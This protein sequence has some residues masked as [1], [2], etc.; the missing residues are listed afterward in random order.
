MKVQTSK[1]FNKQVKKTLFTIVLFILVYILL[2]I[3]AIAAT[4]LLA[5]FGFYIVT[6]FPNVYVWIFGLAL[7]AS[8]LM[9]LFFLFKFIFTKNQN[10]LEGM[11]EIQEADQPELFG[12]IN[13]IVQE[14]ETDFPK[15]VYLTYNVNASVFYNSSFWSMFMPIRKN[16]QIGLGLINSVNKQELKAILAHEFGHFSQRSMKVGS[17]VYNLNQVIYNMLYNN[18]S[19]NNISSTIAGFS[20]IA[21][22][23]MLIPLYSIRGIQALLR[24]LYNFININY[25]AL[26]REM[27]FHADEIAANVAG[28]KA[29]SSSLLR[30]GFAD[31]A[32]NETMNFYID[33]SND[34]IHP[35]N[36][37]ADHQTVSLFLAEKNKYP[38][39]NNLPS[40]DL[41]SNIKYNKSKVNFQDQWASHPSTEDRVMAIQR[42]NIE[43]ENEKV[44]DAI[45]L[46]KGSEELITKISTWLFG[47]GNPELPQINWDTNQFKDA[48]IRDFNKNSFDEYYNDF[49]NLNSP[50]NFDFSKVDFNANT[51]GS[52][53]FFTDDDTEL[54]YELNGIRQDLAILEAIQRNEIKLKTFDYDGKKHKKQETKDL[55]PQLKLAETQKDEELKSINLKI[56]EHYFQKAKSVNREFD[57][58]QTHDTLR[59]FESQLNHQVN[60]NQQVY[61]KLAFLSQTLEFTDI[62][63]NLDNF[64]P[65]EKELKEEI[66]TLVRFPGMKEH[67]HV[68]SQS[69][70]NTFLEK[71]MV[72]FDHGTYLDDELQA[73]STAVRLYIPLIDKRLFLQK[74][75]ILDLKR[76]IQ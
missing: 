54:S 38:I 35:R 46:I 9:I 8:G 48:Y 19:V 41:E 4:G 61:D 25:M 32:L 45:S 60:F 36:I 29:C 50:T 63:K 22:I 59:E 58:R 49:Y 76:E 57:F 40:I 16:L 65:T 68:D 34:N 42:L 23:P 26:S 20:S 39:Q 18:D 43:V 37:Y 69:Q 75:I 72:Y 7:V 17:Y 14:V 5:Y 33:R 30:L 66:K 21:A 51:T 13:E 73:L 44:G 74:K 56:F 31:F 3:A 2:V 24:A 55:I 6:N 12:M 53:M 15:K 47:T 71:E 28:S 1:S 62:F 67:I 11:F 10:S 70:L 64:K 52:N 27:E